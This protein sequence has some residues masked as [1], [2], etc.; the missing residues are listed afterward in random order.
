MSQGRTTLPGMTIR[1]RPLRDA[2]L[3]DLFRWE[4]DPDAIHMA[5]F[6]RQDPTSRAA[7]DAH[8]RRIRSDPT[9]TVRAIEEGERF[10]GT[11]GSFTVE[12]Q[13]EITCWIDPGRWGQGIASEAVRL[14]VKDEAHR[15]LYARA[16]GHNRGSNKVLERNGFLKIGGETAWAAGAGKDVVEHIYRLI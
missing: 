11:I 12:D 13:R 4:N 1:L 6:T 3:D 7:F 16:A 15:P 8:Y 2:D 10:A 5:A 14:F 9:V